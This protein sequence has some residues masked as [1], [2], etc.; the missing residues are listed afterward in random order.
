M[1]ASIRQTPASQPPV[2]PRPRVETE[3]V[4][5]ARPES[6]LALGA[7]PTTAGEHENPV[8]LPIPGFHPRPFLVT[9]DLLKELPPAPVT[10]TRA[11]AKESGIRISR[12]T[13]LGLLS[14]GAVAG[15]LGFTMGNATAGQEKG[16]AAVA[17]PTVEAAVAATPAVAAAA[18]TAREAAPTVLQ[19]EDPTLAAATAQRRQG[20]EWK[21]YTGTFHGETFSFEHPAGWKVTK[22]YNGFMVSHPQNDKLGAAFYWLNGAGEMNPDGLLQMLA[23]DSGAQDWRTVRQTPDAPSQSPIGPVHGV[24]TEATYE[25]RGTP[26]HGR[27][28]SVITVNR[29][30]YASLWYGSMT[31]QSAPAAE[32]QEHAPVLDR[33][34]A[35]FDA[36]MNQG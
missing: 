11:E 9:P 18:V 31:S 28:H 12:W 8:D 3:P 17:A 27:F 29:G 23:K 24:T 1:V 33:I 15:V 32:W 16:N 20:T 10:E 34:V 14:M 22:L 35:S 5:P 2:P 7:P 6:L 4:A 36:S 13:A 30:P 25:L 19:E 21:T 26:S